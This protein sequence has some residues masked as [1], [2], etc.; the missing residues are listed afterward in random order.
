MKG[1]LLYATALPGGIADDQVEIAF[2]RKLVLK[3]ITTHDDGGR[4]LRVGTPEQRREKRPLAHLFLELLNVHRLQF[5]KEGEV[6]AER[7]DS[8]GIGIH[9]NA[10]NPF[11]QNVKQCLSLDLPPAA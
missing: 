1:D 8:A 5:L 10:T 2:Q 11:P 3:E 9:V 6:Q 4:Y 7:R